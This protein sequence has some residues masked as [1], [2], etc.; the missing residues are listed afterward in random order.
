M[1]RRCRRRLEQE[2]KMA[3]ASKAVE[4]THDEINLL[5]MGLMT[6]QEELE[7]EKRSDG[8]GKEKARDR[9]LLPGLIDKINHAKNVTV[10]SG[11]S[12]RLGDGDVDWRFLLPR[13][14]QRSHP[15]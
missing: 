2:N 13:N 4:L 14:K 8:F 3:T 15:K 5:V 11:F 7:K 6:F 10:I 1:S 9:E 12:F